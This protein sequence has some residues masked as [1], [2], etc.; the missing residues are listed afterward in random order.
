[1]TA[2]EVF[3]L[4]EVG[5]ESSTWVRVFADLVSAKRAQAGVVEWNHRA[6]APGENE[7]WEG[8]YDCAECRGLVIER[9]AIEGAESGA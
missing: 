6:E 5:Q 3:V 1:M 4:H 8:P 2:T 7:Q 9:V